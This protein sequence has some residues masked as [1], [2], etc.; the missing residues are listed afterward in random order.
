MAHY[1]PI[2]LIPRPDSTT[3][4]SR[5][6]HGEEHR[7]WQSFARNDFPG[8]FRAY[9]NAQRVRRHVLSERK[10]TSAAIK[11]AGGGRGQSAANLISGVP[12]RCLVALTTELAR[13]ET[14]CG[15]RFEPRQIATGRPMGNSRRSNPPK[16][17][18]DPGEP[19][20]GL[21]Y[22][23][24]RRLGAPRCELKKQRDHRQACR[25]VEG[26]LVIVILVEE[27]AADPRSNDTRHAPRREQQA[28]V[29]ACVLGPP[30]I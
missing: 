19:G 21:C 28:V 20:T 30:E 29:D 13:P 23:C 26:V 8:S 5:S 6:L 10:R 3:A 17:P 2:D 24:P 27:L 22:P 25:S 14:C 16:I 4:K 15:L 1:L 9:V 7:N 18:A 11:W 12:M